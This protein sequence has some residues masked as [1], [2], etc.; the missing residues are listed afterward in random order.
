[1]HAWQSRAQL[2]PDATIR[3]DALDSLARKRTHADGAA[4]FWILPRRRN[5]NLLRLLVAYEVMCDFLDNVGERG[6]SA[7]QVNGRQLNLALVEAL[8]PDAPISD[9]YRHH[10]WCEDGGY[11][12]ALVEACREGCALLPSY[13]RVRSLATREAMRAYVG[14]I[15][16]DPDPHW[17]DAELKRWADGQFPDRRELSWFEITA[18]ASTWFTVHVCF[19]LAAEP[20]CEERDVIESYD[21]YFPWISGTGTMLDSYVDQV[22]DSANGAH[23]Y[24]AHYPDSEVATQRVSE[25]VWRSTYE[26]GRLRN[27]H[28]H[29]VIAACMVAMYLSKDSA[30]T[31]AMQAR[32]RSLIEAGGSLTRLLVPV[33]RGWRLLYGQR[34]A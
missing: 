12:R 27:G 4:L 25:F 28:R 30:R 21:A 17:R 3:E 18:A 33:L 19:A 32:T 10:P 7:G 23:S 34:A 8:D 24:I 13:A 9:Y 15:N 5:L 1:M 29:A 2:I 6:A 11:L 20:T 26:A 16:H 31:P 22:E 14:V